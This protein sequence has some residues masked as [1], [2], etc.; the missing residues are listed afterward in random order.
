MACRLV[1]TGILLFWPLGTNFNGILIEIHA[2]S[3]TKSI[4]KCRLENGSHFV[5]A[6]L[7]PLTWHWLH[8]CTRRQSSKCL[9]SL[10]QG[11]VAVILN[12]ANL[13]DLIAA[14]SLVI[15]LKIGL[16]SS[17]FRSM[18]LSCVTLKFDGW[19]WK[20]IGHLFYATSSFVN[21]L[22]IWWLTSKNNWAPLLCYSKIWASSHSHLWI[23]T[24]DTVRKRP[25]WV[26]IDNFFW[27]CDLEIWQMTL[28]INRTHLLYN[29]KHCAPFHHDMWNQTGVMVRKRISWVLISITLTFDLWPWPFA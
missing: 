13:R 12:K 17:I 15:L 10:L 20:T 1:G 26:E 2:F 19:P 23:Q 25:I 28:K 16:K 7:M 3:M 9:N 4:W 14:T 18:F 11:E 5:S 6:S 21:D 22:E 29:I 8:M 24:G 27:L